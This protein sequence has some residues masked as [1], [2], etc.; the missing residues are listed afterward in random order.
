M[1]KEPNFINATEFVNW[2]EEK[3]SALIEH[4]QSH[5]HEFIKK[6][7]QEIHDPLFEFVTMNFEKHGEELLQ[8]HRLFGNLKIE[9]E[10]ALMKEQKKLFPLILTYESTKDDVLLSELEELVQDAEEGHDIVGEIFDNL[11]ETTNEFK[12]PSGASEAYHG[13]YSKLSKLEKN[14]LRYTFLES[15]ILFP[16]LFGVS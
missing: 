5:H 14:C 1:K 13:M 2:R 3:I 10:Q 9:L 6:M 4:I 16:R 11:G 15:N 12:T 8:V 7:L